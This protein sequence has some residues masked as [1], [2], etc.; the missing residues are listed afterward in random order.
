[1]VHNLLDLSVD[2][3]LSPQ[4]LTSFDVQ[5][6]EGVYVIKSLEE[7]R[8]RKGTFAVIL[9]LLERDTGLRKRKFRSVADVIRQECFTYNLGRN[10][11]D[12][13]NPEDVPDDIQSIPLAA[14]ELE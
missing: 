9:G 6:A 1:M 10:P 7:L 11:L 8:L 13:H 14:N 3:V 2:L 4:H 12:W 5:E